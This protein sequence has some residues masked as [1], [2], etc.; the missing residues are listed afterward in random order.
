MGDLQDRP[1]LG[2]GE[3]FA[4]GEIL[5]PQ[6]VAVPNNLGGDVSDCSGSYLNTLEIFRENHTSYE[7]AS[8]K[9]ACRTSIDA[10]KLRFTCLKDKQLHSH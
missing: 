10:F 5:Q 2:C 8:S 7:S 6:N 9:T 1:P 3:L 4:T